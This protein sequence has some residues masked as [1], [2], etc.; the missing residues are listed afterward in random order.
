MFLKQNL[1]NSANIHIVFC[2]RF[3][4]IANRECNSNAGIL[5]LCCCVP[6]FRYMCIKQQASVLYNVGGLL[7]HKLEGAG[8]EK[9]SVL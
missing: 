1:A 6:L 3:D 8:K 5:L 2:I 9:L 7:S 4:S